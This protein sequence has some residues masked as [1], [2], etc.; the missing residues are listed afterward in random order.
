MGQVF[1][2]LLRQANLS[3]RNQQRIFLGKKDCEQYDHLTEVRHL[4]AREQ[5]RMKPCILEM[6][7]RKR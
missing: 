1:C 6:G 7:G 2:A 5:L 4:L 3:A